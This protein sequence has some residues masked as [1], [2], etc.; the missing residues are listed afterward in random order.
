[1]ETLCLDPSPDSLCTCSTFL[2]YHIV[3]RH[4]HWIAH[5]K[6]FRRP[7]CCSPESMTAEETTAST[8]LVKD[9][10]PGSSI[11]EVHV[12]VVDMQAHLSA[13]FHLGT[14]MPLKT[15]CSFSLPTAFAA[16]HMTAA[17]SG[18]RHFYPPLSPLS[19]SGSK[20][21]QRHLQ[22]ENAS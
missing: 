10:F 17:A 15:R 12:L 21:L 7:H 5:T 13:G 16:S 19:D 22:R 18:S 4:E 14:Q 8:S 2:V 9:C 3:F 20:R 11:E 6:L 1:M